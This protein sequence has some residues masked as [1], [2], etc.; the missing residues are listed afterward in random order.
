MI[1]EIKWDSHSVL[2]DLSLDFTKPNGDLYNTIIFAGENGCGKTTIL[3][4]LS[5]F[6]NLGSFEPFSHIKYSV[7]GTM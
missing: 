7:D 6:L 2:G 1:K 5:T 3:S 4:T